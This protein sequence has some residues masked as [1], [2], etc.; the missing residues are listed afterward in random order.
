MKN[1]LSLIIIVIVFTSFSFCQGLKFIVLTANGS[2]SLTRNSNTANLKA[3]EKI[4]DNDKL[5]VGKKSYLNLV[6]QDGK[7]L[8]IKAAGTYNTAKLITM[9]NSK[10][11]SSA[12]KFSN[13]VLAEFV[14]SVDDLGNMKVTGAV[15]RIIKASIDYCTPPNTNIVD[16]IITFSWYSVTGNSYT[17]KLTD[18]SGNVL[19]STESNDTSLTLNLQQLNLSRDNNFKWYVKDNKRQKALTDTCRFYW[20]SQAK[21]DSIK[22]SVNSFLKDFDKVDHSIKQTLLASFYSDNKLYIDMLQAYSRAIELSPENITYKKLYF[23]ALNKAGLSRMASSY[24]S[25]IN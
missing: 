10:K 23:A 3:G 9:V 4:L 8:E 18:F 16:P 22:K 19:Y 2:I 12:K 5:K 21:A 15:E 14:K 13:F 11:N 7:T 20:M 25:Q 1:L 24:K 17:L 6:Y